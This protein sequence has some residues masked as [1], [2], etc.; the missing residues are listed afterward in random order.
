MDVEEVV[1]YEYEVKGRFSGW[2]QPKDDP[3]WTTES[4]HELSGGPQSL[5]LTSRWNWANQWS[6]GNWVYDNNL[7]GRFDKDKGKCRRRNWTRFKIRKSGRRVNRSGKHEELEIFENE[8][9]NVYV[10][11]KATIESQGRHTWTDIEG[12]QTNL[13][14]KEPSLYDHWRWTNSWTISTGVSTD[15]DGWT[16]AV[17]WFEVPEGFSKNRGPLSRVRRRKW[18]RRRQHTQTQDFD[19]TELF[20]QQCIFLAR[21]RFG[22]F[23]QNLESLVYNKMTADVDVLQM[24]LSVWGPTVPAEVRDIKFT[25]QK[26]FED[27]ELELQHQLDL[28]A[29]TSVD[30]EKAVQLV[31]QINFVTR[32]PQSQTNI[33]KWI[34]SYIMEPIK[35]TFAL[36][37]EYSQLK[38][39]KRRFASYR[40]RIQQLD[41][42]W[43]FVL[44]KSWNVPYR[45]A[46]EFCEIT[47][48]QLDELFRSG[49]VTD[50]VAIIAV[51]RE[52][53]DFEEELSK[54]LIDDQQDILPEELR[55]NLPRF[56]GIFIQA[57]EE[58][59]TCYVELE[60]QSAKDYLR[61]FKIEQREM[62]TDMRSPLNNE[63]GP[64]PSALGLLDQIKKGIRHC[65][66]ITRGKTLL[67]LLQSYLGVL[68][69]YGDDVVS[70]ASIVVNALKS[71]KPP[72]PREYACIA[73]IFISRLVDCAKF[74]SESLPNLEDV[75]KKALHRSLRDSF[76]T[77]H[78]ATT[79]SIIGAETQNQVYEILPSRFFVAGN[80]LISKWKRGGNKAAFRQIQEA[81]NE[82]WLDICLSFQRQIGNVR[83]NGVLK[84]SLDIFCKNLISYILQLR[85]NSKGGRVVLEQVSLLK[86]NFEKTTGLVLKKI[87]LTRTFSRCLERA[88]SK[89]LAVCACITAEDP[90]ELT[91]QFLTTIHTLDDIDCKLED[92]LE[93]RRIDQG[94]RETCM[95]L[96]NMRREEFEAIAA[97]APKIDQFESAPSPIFIPSEPDITSKLGLTPPAQ[98]HEVDLDFSSDSEDEEPATSEPDHNAEPVINQPIVTVVE[99]DS[100]SDEEEE[101]HSQVQPSEPKNLFAS[102]PKGTSEL[103]PFGTTSASS[104][105]KTA[106]PNPFSETKPSPNPFVSN[107]DPKPNPFASDTTTKPIPFASDSTSTNPFGSD[108]TPDPPRTNPFGASD[109]SNKNSFASSDPKPSSNPFGAPS[110]T[111]QSVT[112]LQSSTNPF[113]SATSATQPQ[114][115][116]NPFGSTQT[117]SSTNP[118][119][120]SQ[121][122]TNPL[123]ASQT[124][125]NPFGSSDREPAAKPNPFKKETSNDS[126]SKNPF[127]ASEPANNPFA[128]SENTLSNNQPSN[129]FASSRPAP[130][131]FYS[132]VNEPKEAPSSPALPEILFQG[133]LHKQQ[134]IKKKWQKR[135][136]KLRREAEIRFYEF[137][138]DESTNIKLN[139]ADVKSIRTVSDRLAEFHLITNN[140]DWIFRADSVEERKQWV[141]L[142]QYA[143]ENVGITK[144]KEIEPNVVPA[145]PKLEDKTSQVLSIKADSN[146]SLLK[147]DIYGL[148]SE[149][150]EE[151]SEEDGFAVF[152]A[153]DT[154]KVT[155]RVGFNSAMNGT[156][157]RGDHIH[158]G[159]VYYQ[160]EKHKF[161][162]RWFA[163][164][165]M[166]IFDWRGLNNDNVCAA[167][168]LDDVSNPTLVTHDW[169]VFDGKTKKWHRDAMLTVKELS[170]G[171]IVSH[172]ADD[173]QSEQWED[174]DDI[175][176]EEAPVIPNRLSQQEAEKR[177]SILDGTDGD[178][179]QIDVA[180]MLEEMGICDL[181]LDEDE[182]EVDE[183]I[184][185]DMLLSGVAEDASKKE[186]HPEPQKLVS[187]KMEIKENT[188]NVADVIDD[189]RIEDLLAMDIGVS[190]DD[191]E[192]D[193]EELLR[194]S[195]C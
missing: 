110:T 105:P 62:F 55:K 183:E 14:H 21:D 82:D 71:S 135:W 52:L 64:L 40:R 160:H 148:I 84:H 38:Y 39:M 95:K 133:W 37:E 88:F 178:E 188:S 86:E 109:I 61:A 139:L 34:S 15:R 186:V 102:D 120:T 144:A 118:F 67:F 194:N 58:N 57:M 131:P 80:Y 100:S 66:S 56:E 8:Y 158:D 108:P 195:E 1:V 5:R 190:D 113:G 142:V 146:D 75:A 179:D 153:P 189:I 25:L 168:G 41:S 149:N 31:E 91:M 176:V 69:T 132:P 117:S 181:S 13:K 27:A 12:K 48:F 23:Q 116:T 72:K 143:Q 170:S 103:N 112:E 140:R 60:L 97:A 125:T 79:F 174:A 32:H 159:R 96:F 53:Q 36:G 161:V 134:L 59:L 187:T 6:I 151:S 172:A 51:L 193:I 175:S 147:K 24:I 157:K 128:T 30:P 85:C 136:C 73:A 107:S 130:N 2:S 137:E 90:R 7:Q 121:A 49:S 87:S 93:L 101:V 150:A 33:C 119:G 54:S 11:E 171:K 76:V 173:P 192:I 169:R 19:E 152:P 65:I 3:R 18:I 154:V 162:I 129:P 191:E 43:N 163:K 44:P 167:A 114:T 127:A 77:Q 138:S 104:E 74:I 81:I 123:G 156:Y 115:S 46:L 28:I 177:D 20:N 35:A 10:W 155:G 4:G 166:W 106:A 180:Q 9:F 42:S 78:Q 141:M 63:K 26:A 16:Y 89:P 70:S 50:P 124:S 111:S 94:T 29:K 99:N 145:P 122:S 185:I 184:D 98:I 182:E 68:T 83:L 22:A 47:V 17:G 126:A 92:I 164:K 165:K 45:C